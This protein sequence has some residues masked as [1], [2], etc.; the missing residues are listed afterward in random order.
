MPVD[1]RTQRII[2]WRESFALLPDNH[3]FEII[4]M[5]LGEIKTPF[6]K[7]KLI[8]ELGAFIRKEETRKI[9]ISLL[10]ESDLQLICAVKFISNA[11]EEKLALFF[12]NT[13]SFAELYARLLNLEERLI[14]Y[15]HV[16][17]ASGKMIVS[18]NPHLEEDFKNLADRKVLLENPS[19]S[20]LSDELQNALSPEL[21]AS[22]ISFIYKNPDICKAD[23][24]FKK[25]IES[26]IEKLFPGRTPLLHCLTVAFINLSLIRESPQGFEIDRNKFS[27]FTKLPEIIQYAYFCVAS[28]GRFSRGMLVRQ[29]KLL[30]DVA[31][32][33][34]EAGYAR[35]ILLRLAY[36]I[37]ED[38]GDVPGISSFGSASRFSAMLN[39]ARQTQESD[40]VEDLSAIGMSEN[41]SS[42]L[43]RLIDSAEL[44]GILSKKGTD[45]NGETVYVSGS[46]FDSVEIDRENEPKVLSIDAAFNVTVLPGLS[47]GSL[48]PLMNF[49]EL[50]QF[51][52]AALFEINRKSVM[53]GFDAG[54]SEEKI[55]SLLKKYCPYEL[56]Q[57]LEVS[58]EDWG[59]SYS[60]ATIFKG[61]I[62]QVSGENAAITENNPAIAPF[63]SATL[64]PGIYLLSVE[65]DAEASEVISKSG[66]DFIGKI[67]TAEKSYESL[68]FPEFTFT[69]NKNVS[70]YNYDEYTDA[71][72]NEILKPGKECERKAHFDKMREELEKMEMPQENREGLLQRIDHKIVL[73]VSQ[74]RPESVHFE[75]IEAGGMDFSGKLHIIEGS[76]SNNSMVELHFESPVTDSGKNIKDKIIIGI[77][78]SVTKTGADAN[79]LIEVLPDHSEKLLSIGQ[80]K[81]VKRIRGS[82]LR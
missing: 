23:G 51:D 46:I 65:N 33:I 72:G 5:Y 55:F 74:L 63:I 57:N 52:T 80:A 78:I 77:P 20:E 41:L 75:R 39:R 25:R 17:K 58:V 9:L 10:S 21:I 42:I 66:L 70:E 18:L 60:S 48:L 31:S 40:G 81:F 15:R 13:F 35:T 4:R 53:R 44:M 30:L 2:N 12:E 61:Y 6:N 11:T 26:E 69:K 1:S 62:L 45:E 64:A 22:F 67:K 56:P 19:M 43:D 82:V 49:L 54:L 7:Q 37:S 47:L 68:A 29:A 73:S 71:N 16:D 8:E 28:Q 27:S 76:I 3:F 32:A 36:L 38:Q 34:P 79:V 14:I 50:K 24:T 59:K